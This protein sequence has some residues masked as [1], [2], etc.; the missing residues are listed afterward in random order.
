MTTATTTAKKGDGN[1][2]D[3]S[4]DNGEKGDGD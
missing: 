1:Q 2:N 4:N 3:D